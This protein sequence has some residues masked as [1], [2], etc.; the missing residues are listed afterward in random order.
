MTQL[1]N[2]NKSSSLCGSWFI[3]VA[4]EE[5]EEVPDVLVEE[6]PEVLVEEVPIQV[7][8]EE[9]EEVVEVD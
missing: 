4:E 6:V 3:T 8:A 1:E 7:K 2:R 5:V 9:E